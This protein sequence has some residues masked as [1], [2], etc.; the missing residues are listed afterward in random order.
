MA[1]RYEVNGADWR[2]SVSDDGI[3]RLDGQRSARE[4]GLGTTLVKALAHQLEAK[5]ETT[6]SPAGVKVSV[7]HSTFVS[8]AA[9][10]PAK[11]QPTDWAFPHLGSCLCGRFLRRNGN[12]CL[13]SG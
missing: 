13:V 1:V 12:E 6:S 2:L 3:G 8:R 10:W 7:A 9:A 4:G 5:V 11:S